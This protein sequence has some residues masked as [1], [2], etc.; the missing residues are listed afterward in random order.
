LQST[1]IATVYARGMKIGV[2]AALVF[3]CEPEGSTK[4]ASQLFSDTLN[5]PFPYHRIS[6]CRAL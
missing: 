2:T 1:T 5:S 4:L 6:S 3:V